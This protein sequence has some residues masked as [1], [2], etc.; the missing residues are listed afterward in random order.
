MGSTAIRALCLTP[1]VA[2]GTTAWAEGSTRHAA[3]SYSASGIV[4]ST[5]YQPGPFAPNTIVT[6]FGSDLAYSVEAASSL[7]IVSN[8]LPTRL[9]RVQVLAMRGQLGTPLPLHYASPGQINFVLPGSAVPGDLDICVVREGISGPVVRIPLQD[10]APALIPLE[11]GWLTATHADGALVTPSH[12]ARP[13][14]W[15][16]LYATGLGPTVQRLRDGEVPGLQPPSI[17]GYAI[18]RLEEFRVLF[19]GRPLE[20]ARIY[21]AGLTPGVTAL[22]QVNAQVPEDAPA[23]PEIRIAIGERSSQEG[24]KLPLQP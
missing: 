16:V 21:Y 10:V 7:N 18:A 23:D 4:V 13:G 15:V 1:V 14:E 11:T 3:P 2:F 24:L 6:V 19:A 22:Y 9:A 17:A 12:P 20:R 8:L 5:T